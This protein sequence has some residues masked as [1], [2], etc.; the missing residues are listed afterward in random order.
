MMT[1][2]KRESYKTEVESIKLKQSPE[3]IL[4]NKSRQLL[5][6]LVKIIVLFCNKLTREK[7]ILTSFMDHSE[8]FQE[9]YQFQ[10]LLETLRQKEKNL[11]AILML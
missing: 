4:T 6:S 10:E 9:D 2:N 11:E 8:S 1:K 7:R 3:E 5:T